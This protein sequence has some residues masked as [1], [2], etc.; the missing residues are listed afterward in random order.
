VSLAVAA[1]RVLDAGP[2]ET[3]GLAAAV[4]LGSRLPDVISSAR[5]YTDARGVSGARCWAMRPTRTPATADGVRA[6]RVASVGT[7][8]ALVCAAVAALAALVAAPAG[9]GVA[10]VV[11]AEL[12]MAVPRLGGRVPLDVTAGGQR[13]DVL[14]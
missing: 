2:L 6:G 13:R 7:H 1:G 3:T 10:L 8:L 5:A 9:A 4:L 14:G 11:A 12:A